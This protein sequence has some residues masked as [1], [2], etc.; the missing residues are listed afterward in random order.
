MKIKLFTLILALAAAAG[1][2]AQSYHLPKGGA[3]TIQIDNSMRFSLDMMGQ[4]IEN[5]THVQ[6]TEALDW[7]S[8][9]DSGYLFSAKVLHVR[10]EGSAMGQQYHADSD[11]SNALDPASAAMVK[12]VGMVQKFWVDP[13][14]KISDMDLGL[15][16]ISPSGDAMVNALG[17]MTRGMNYPNLLPGGIRK[18]KLGDTWQD[19]LPA[20][21][22]V[23][24][25]THYR[26][27]RLTKDSIVLALSGTFDFKGTIPANGMEIAMTMGGLRSGEE[28]YE[29]STG[30]LY[31]SH[32]KMDGKGEMEV[33]SNKIPFTVFNNMSNI[34]QR[35]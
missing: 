3:P 16:E 18:L 31:I 30:L 22:P 29:R 26:V 11:S 1:L 23:Q 20:G 17:G 7:T 14:G 8:R 4:T 10:T 13:K 5:T 34:L 24:M 25:T 15:K 19:S 35:K 2:R 9:G 32:T 28:S 27:A 33:M 21:G 12:T 6:M